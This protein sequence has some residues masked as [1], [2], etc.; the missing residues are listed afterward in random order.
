MMKQKLKYI[1]LKSGYNDDG[2]AWIGYV[3]YS[4]SGKTVYFNDHAFYGNGHGGSHDMETGEIYWITG[5]KKNG[6]NRHVYG[7]GKIQIE[8]RAVEAYEAITGVKVHQNKDFEI[9]KIEVTSKERFNKLYNERL[10]D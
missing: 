1:E 4:K 6:S 8:D 5:I 7:R 10:A 2:P 3:E 9:V